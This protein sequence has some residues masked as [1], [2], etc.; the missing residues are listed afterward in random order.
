MNDIRRVEIPDR[1]EEQLPHSLRIA[2][3]R[4]AV[5]SIACQTPDDLINLRR[6]ILSYME[7]IDM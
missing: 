3:E 5:C 7:M 4:G 6:G 1:D 2:A